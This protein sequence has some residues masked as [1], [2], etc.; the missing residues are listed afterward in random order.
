MARTMKRS[1]K[2]TAKKSSTVKAESKPTAAE[3]KAAEVGKRM[4][5]KWE[6]GAT[7]ADVC[8]EAGWKSGRSH[9]I[10]AAGSLDAFVKAQAR[11]NALLAKQTRRP[12]ARA[13][14]RAAKRSR[15]AKHSPKVALVA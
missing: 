8:K 6:K 3:S 12:L 10:S 9:L 14:K 7:Y 2:S 15:S 4:L 1:T 13:A 5:A 11:R